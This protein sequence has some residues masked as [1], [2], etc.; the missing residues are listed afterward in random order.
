MSYNYNPY[1]IITFNS[2]NLHIISVNNEKNAVAISWQSG[3]IL[4]VLSQF[5]QGIYASEFVE[6]FLELAPKKDIPVFFHTI[7]RKSFVAAIGRMRTSG[8]IEPVK[9]KY[10]ITTLGMK[11]IKEYS[12][13]PDLTHLHH[14]S[15]PRPSPDLLRS[16]TGFP[17]TTIP[18]A[19]K[20]NSQN[21]SNSTTMQ[22]TF[23]ANFKK[24]LAK[25]KI[26]IKANSLKGTCKDILER[27]KKSL[28][29][30]QESPVDDL[31]QFAIAKLFEFPTEI[32]DTTSTTIA[33]I[34][35]V[36]WDDYCP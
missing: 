25:E 7:K 36:C 23:I 27:F 13:Y 32:P 2:F 17:S 16:P 3:Y 9:N 22:D 14:Y 24:G 10:K 34:L 15:P 28:A 4:T 12:N 18:R 8:L 11:H 29:K 5:P 33:E 6:L 26:K 31:V 20:F 30:S 19:K 35:E 1:F 21:I